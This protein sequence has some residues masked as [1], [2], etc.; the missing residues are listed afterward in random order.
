LLNANKC[1]ASALKLK[2]T[3]ARTR[4]AMWASGSPVNLLASALLKKLPKKLF[5]R[6]TFRRNLKNQ[7]QKL[8][9]APL[10]K[11]SSKCYF[12]SLK[13]ITGLFA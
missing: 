9:H 6:K 12:S 7:K 11:G 2:N 4:T 3:E 5:R 13:V 1:E 8:R 10:K